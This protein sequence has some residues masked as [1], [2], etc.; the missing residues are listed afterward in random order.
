MNIKNSILV[1]VRIAFLMVFL[2]SLAVVGKIFHLQLVQGDKWRHMAQ[3]KTINFQKVKATRGNI[4]SDNGN[5]LATSLPFY[6]LALD[7]SVAD[8]KL[9]KQGLDSLAYLLSVHF[10]DRSPEEYKR[11]INNARQ[12]KRKY[13]M[14][15]SRMINYQTKKQMET[16]PILRAGRYK[17]GV[18]FE[19]TDRRFNPFAAL[20][21]RTIGYVN[22][23]SKGVVGLEA[24]F[25]KQLAGKD[26]QALFQRMAGG[27][28]KPLNDGSEVPPEQ[29][30]DI[31]TTIDINL[32]DVAQDALYRAVT[33]HQ[34]NYGCVVVMEV[35][36]GEIK[37]M[38]NLGK[39]KN[40]GYAETYNFVVGQQ[41]RT[42]PGSTFKL[43]S[44]IAL[45]EETQIEPTDSIDTGNGTF[46]YNGAVM[47]D[48]KPGGYG[49]I[50]V[51]QAF[52]HSSNVAFVMMMRDH[53]RGKAQRY[54][55]YLDAFGLTR[56]LGFQ[57]LGEAV[58]YI[59]RPEDKTWSG[60]TLPWM[61]VGYE[62]KMSPLHILA[63]YN[64]I[65][66]NGKMIQ[67]IIVK[68]ARITDNA[69]EQYQA[70][71]INE[72]VC[73]DRTLRIVRKMLE[74]VVERGT[75][76]SIRNNDYKIAGKTG[77]SQKL[78]DG[79]Y[80]REYYTSFAGYF[81][82]DK[83]KYSCI[84]VIDGPQGYR[85]YGAEVAA[86]VFKEIADK[87]YARDLE[88]HKL[89]TAETAPESTA[90]PLVKA[91]HFEDL[92]YLCNQMGISNHGRELEEWVVANVSDNS[93]SWKNK[94]ARKDE[95][96]D[97]T[98]MTLKDALYILENQGL[99][100]NYRGRGRVVSQSQQAGT[101]ILPGSSIEV[102]LN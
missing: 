102:V 6:R 95:V 40:G 27:G 66:N 39:L 38:A 89:L 57:M 53:F 17:G 62:S 92:R 94:L 60:I 54:I 4:I 11:R 2:F 99:K 97:V 31:Q 80:T 18:I 22:Q 73:S 14:L 71:V 43:P 13:L 63:F 25:N 79:R 33:D 28:W 34:A 24:S 96:P 74:G 1:R 51:Q 20:G 77:T 68:E 86:P 47:N 56:P 59:K 50:T 7:P 19:R 82:A 41:G 10:K 36:T 76:K 49:K 91:G 67:P 52:E 58:P 72:K 87:V 21:T 100:V 8:N 81:P 29:G 9:Y 23:Q 78:K 84:V 3:E 55:E 26:G 12:E 15:N 45:L 101:H 83:P 65:A 64:A 48:S 46:R 61:A 93:I 70:R 88:M 5:L 30:W 98:G 32:Q 16:W 85:Q 35:A 69:E 42:D 75:A 37:A 44:M 90:F